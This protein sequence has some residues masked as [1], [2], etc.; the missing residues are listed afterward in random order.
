MWVH[1]GSR[2]KTM[3]NNLFG[4]RRASLCKNKQHLQVL[5]LQNDSGQ[6]LKRVRTNS[7]NTKQKEINMNIKEFFDKTLDKRIEEECK[8]RDLKIEEKFYKKTG[9]KIKINDVALKKKISVE[10]YSYLK[11]LMKEDTKNYRKRLKTVSVLTVVITSLCFISLL[12]S[13]TTETLI[14]H[15]AICGLLIYINIFRPI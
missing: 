15:L 9:I 8:I 10:N 3:E 1:L 11:E 6:N 13:L 5:K 4:K 7:T 14:L 12:I 2:K